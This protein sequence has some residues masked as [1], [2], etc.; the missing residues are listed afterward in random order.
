MTNGIIREPGMN[1]ALVNIRRSGEAR[2][3]N[4]KAEGMDS[5]SKYLSEYL[6]YV[7]NLDNS[8]LSYNLDIVGSKTICK[9]PRN[10]K[11]VIAN[12]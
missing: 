12:V 2:M 5:T 6:R 1:S 8:P 11:V 3:D 4:P 7:F 9:G 10:K